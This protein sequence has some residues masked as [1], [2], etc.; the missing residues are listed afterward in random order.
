MFSNVFHS[1]GE[2]ILARLRN[3]DW[4]AVTVDRCRLSIDD[5]RELLSE[6]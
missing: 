6:M 5:I 1:D 2:M 4:N 3:C